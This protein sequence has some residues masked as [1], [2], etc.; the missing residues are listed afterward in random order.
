MR[1]MARTCAL[2]LVIAQSACDAPVAPTASPGETPVAGGRLVL[3]VRGDVQT[4]QPVLATDEGAGTLQALIYWPMLEHDPTG[5]LRPGLADRF[6]ISN[7]GR[8]A[9]FHFA[10]GARWSDGVPVTA[11]DYRY[12]VSAA[13]RSKKAA[14][15]GARFADILGW[16]DY[17]EGRDAELRGIR[18]LDGGRTVEVA[19]TRSRCTT[20]ENLNL[21]PLP[22]HRFLAEWD[23]RTTDLSRS[24]DTSTFNM[25]PPVSSGPFLFRE[26]RPKDQL[27]LAR[28]GQFFRG[29]PLLESIVFTFLETTAATRD[30]FITGASAQDA[31]Q[32]EDVDYVR[33]RMG[34]SAREYQFTDT[35]TYDFIAWN[36]KAAAAPWLADR[37]VRQALWYGLDVKTI[38]DRVLLGFAHPVYAHTPPP[39]WAYDGSGLN[40]YDYDPGRA[41]ALLESAGAVMGADGVYRWTDGRVMELHIET[42]QDNLTRRQIAQIAQEQYRQ[43]GIRA[44]PVL[45][46]FS[47]LVTRVTPAGGSVEGVLLGWAT[48]ADPDDA[49]NIWHTG[50]GFNLVAMGD[51]RVDATLDAARFG[52][53]CGIAARKKAY[54]TMNHILNEEAPYVFLFA[55]DTVLFAR[56]SLVRPAPQRFAGYS[57]IERWW[58]RP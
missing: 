42:N 41:R 46:A 6:A 29:P 47:T 19:L 36:Q 48:G 14:V 52:P 43:I 45:E 35:F 23:D 27:V 33:Q 37:R 12:A 28:N 54:S 55:K 17:A 49:Y 8:T 24:I 56:T 31:P 44:V 3:A 22:R 21:M 5:A 38:A 20:L 7:D 13:A 32:P 40:H 25:A 26:Y 4:L 39:S 15:R 50:G 11:D 2:A 34:G 53:D 30:A 58:I 51:A 10:D 16:S 9:T 57:G 1:R 18:S